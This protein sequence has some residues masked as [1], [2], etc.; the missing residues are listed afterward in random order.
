M[1]LQVYF[2]INEPG[3]HWALGVL[4]IRT[5]VV[6]VYD[7]LGGP[8]EEGKPWWEAWFANFKSV[9]PPYLEKEG[10]MA[11]K[12]IDPS[13]YSITFRYP[14]GVPLQGGY[15]GDCGIWLC[16]FLYRLT[17][18]LPIMVDDPVHFALAYREHLTNFYWKYKTAVEYEDDES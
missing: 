3:V 1:I 4:E 9:I 7:T 5:G 18:N 6:N 17:H 16:I 15:Y 2:P 12:N 8:D 13:T 10:V 14:D 11:K